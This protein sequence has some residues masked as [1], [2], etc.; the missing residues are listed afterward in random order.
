MEMFKGGSNIVPKC[1]YTVYVQIFER[2]DPQGFHNQLSIHEIF[3]LNEI[4]IISLAST[5]SQA[6]VH[7][8]CSFVKY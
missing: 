5:P 8:T 4:L 6:V 2:C 7:I 1:P 3:I